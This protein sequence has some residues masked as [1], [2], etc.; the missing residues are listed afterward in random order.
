MTDYVRSCPHCKL[1]YR[2][3][4][5]IHNDPEVFCPRCGKRLVEEK[6]K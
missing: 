1:V 5:R 4:A 2:P 3:D 6:D